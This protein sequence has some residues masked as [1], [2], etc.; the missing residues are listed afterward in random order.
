MKI[1]ISIFFKLRKLYFGK[2][3]LYFNNR[4]FFSSCCKKDS[5][6]ISKEIKYIINSLPQIMGILIP[7]ALVFQ[8]ISKNDIE[9]LRL[10]YQNIYN[11]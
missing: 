1:E 6:I 7:L 2:T 5:E 11:L 10:Y 9:K 4:H 3:F 8:K